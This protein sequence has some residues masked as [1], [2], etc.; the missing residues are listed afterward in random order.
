MYLHYFKEG[1][2]TLNWLD[3]SFA[4]E[5]QS[6]DVNLFEAVVKVLKAEQKKA[7]RTIIACWSEGSR[8]R[9]EYWNGRSTAVTT[10]FARAVQAPWSWL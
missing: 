10:P 3:P 2:P 4:A 8:D 6:Q 1:Q 7:R 5:R 9:T